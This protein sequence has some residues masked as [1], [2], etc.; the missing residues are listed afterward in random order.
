MPI[1]TLVVYLALIGLALW[2]ITNYIPMPPQ[3]KTLIVVVVV[4]FIVIWLLQLTNLVAIG[5][6][7][8]RLR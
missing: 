7:V 3:I 4:V 8:P 6:T 5:P 1:L 2:L